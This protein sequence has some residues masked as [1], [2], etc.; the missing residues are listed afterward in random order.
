MSA[1]RVRVVVLGAGY[2]AAEVRAYIQDL[3]SKGSAIELVGFLDD[4]RPAGLHDGFRILGKIEDLS[5]GRIAD[6]S[7]THFITAVG[8]NRL[9]ERMVERLTAACGSGLAAWSMIHSAAWTGED[10]EIGGGT[11]LAPAAL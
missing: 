11:C 6:L 1:S 7:V 5:G 3:V 4:G 10:V 9:R 8:N 2:H